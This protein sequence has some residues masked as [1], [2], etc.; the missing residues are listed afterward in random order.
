MKHKKNFYNHLIVIDTIHVGLDT[1]E[2]TP[3]EKQELLDL[4]EN[5]I[6]HKVIDTVLSELKSQIKKHFLY[7]FWTTMNQKFGSF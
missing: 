2:L 3:E 4:A 6:H 5:N 7:W 1:L